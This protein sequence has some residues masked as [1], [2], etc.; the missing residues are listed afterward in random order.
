MATPKENKTKPNP[1]K[2]AVKKKAVAKKTPSRKKN[3]TKA[4]KEKE[5]LKKINNVLELIESGLSLRKALKMSKVGKDTF[6][7][8]VEGSK[9]NEERY[10]RACDERA[11]AIMDEA[12]DIADDNRKDSEIRFDSNGVPYEVED[13]EYTSRSKM[14]VNLRQW[15]LTKLKP[16]KYGDKIEVE[17]KSDITIS[18]K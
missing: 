18:F 4:K 16:K 6:Y 3:L 5:R 10:L 11:E 17:Q 12:Y 1:K 14:K 2:E 13:K 15:H 7:G 8:W 9:E